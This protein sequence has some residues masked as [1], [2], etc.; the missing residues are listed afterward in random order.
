MLCRAAESTYGRRDAP[1]VR[2]SWCWDEQTAAQIL[3]DQ[4][5]RYGWQ[6]RALRLAVPLAQGERLEMWSVVVVDDAELYISGQ[7]A[8]VSRR[9]RLDSLVIV[10]L[11]LLDSP[12]DTKSITT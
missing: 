9:E 2:I 4:S 7:V 11:I 12:A 5:D 1:N 8:L 6:R 10:D 3:A